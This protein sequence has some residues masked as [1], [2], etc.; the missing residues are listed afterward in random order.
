MFRPG[1]RSQPH[2][3]SRRHQA[4]QKKACLGTTRSGPSS[5]EL[6]DP[7]NHVVRDGPVA[8]SGG[9]G[10]PGRVGGTFQEG[11]N[12]LLLN[13]YTAPEPHPGDLFMKCGTMNLGKFREMVRDRDLAGCSP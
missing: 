2:S 7:P 9:M 10:L 6:Q 8:S 4:E 11:G 12:V 1:L 5:R 13:A 3:T